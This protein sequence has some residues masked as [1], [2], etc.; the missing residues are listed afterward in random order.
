MKNKILIPLVLIMAGLI[1][2]S[3]GHTNK[4]GKYDLQD[5]KILFDE[6]F[7][8]NVQANLFLHNEPVRTG[9]T[10]ADVVIDV[11]KAIAG[12]IVEGNAEA[13]LINA[14]DPKYVTESISNELKSTLVKYL[15]ISP[16]DKPSDKFS[17]I[18]T[19]NIREI[20]LNSTEFDI[21]LNVD[22]EVEITEQGSADV[23]W[24]YCES[25]TV[26]LRNYLSRVNN[27]NFDPNVSDIIQMGQ[28]LAL[29][30]SQL[31]QVVNYAAIEIGEEFSR[32]FRKDLSKARGK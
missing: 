30:E 3:C 28:L 4:L 8:G 13:K 19:T 1:I 17:Y 21:F 26:S 25:R 6:Q 18:V 15:R 27:G 31:R 22:A 7:T 32:Q 16:T 20:T 23:V 9:S 2:Q 29:S 11:G 14:A 24:D 10:V 12:G 5:K